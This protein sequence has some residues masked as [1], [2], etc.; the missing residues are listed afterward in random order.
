MTHS[1]DAAH[2]IRSAYLDLFWLATRLRSGEVPGHRVLDIRTFAERSLAEHK[3]A[4]LRADVDDQTIRDAELAIIALLDE[5]A[6]QSCAHDCAEV[7]GA[8]LLQLDHFNHSNL[9]RDFFDRLELLRQRPETPLALLEIYA[10][11]LALGFEGRFRKDD[12]LEDLR[13]LKDAL[14]TE[15]FHRMERLPLN[16]PQRELAAPPLPPPL[17]AAHKVLGLAAVMTLLVGTLL[18]LAIYVRARSTTESL[19]KLLLPEG[20]VQAK[21]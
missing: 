6:Q 15:L 7:W 11:C 16:P 19:Q 2:A 18:T 20:A 10:R 14:R 8:R 1:A 12:K 3:R 17:F 5:S 9:G 21:E 4:L 13:V